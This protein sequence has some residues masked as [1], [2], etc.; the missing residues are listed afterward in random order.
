[1]KKVTEVYICDICGEEK[2]EVQ[3]IN[4]PVLFITEQTEGRST[5]SYISQQN[6]DVCKM[7]LGKVVKIQG[8]GAMGYNNYKII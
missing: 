3:T 8:E 4:Y 2:I 1:M 5:D 7:C 6:I